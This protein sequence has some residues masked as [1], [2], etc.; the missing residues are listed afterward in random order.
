[1]K[2]IVIALAILLVATP[3]FALGPSPVDPYGGTNSGVGSPEGT[4][5]TRTK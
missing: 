4:L 1:M 2:K 3:A 5:P